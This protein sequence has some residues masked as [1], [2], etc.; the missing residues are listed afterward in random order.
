M[1]TQVIELI[2]RNRL[3]DELFMAGLEVAIPERDCGV[4]VIAYDLGSR[5][6]PFVARP[7]Q[8]K[9]ATGENFSIDQR[10]REMRGLILAFVWHVNDQRKP[11]T[12]ALTWREAL[13]IG[14]A[15]GWTETP[16]W[17]KHG[18]YTTQR[19]SQ[20]LLQLLDE[21]QMTP[22]LWRRKVRESR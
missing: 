5:S 13:A 6:I 2:G 15:M 14:R 3:I 11:V 12:Y 4:D 1:D 9:A 21:H 18:K 20:E 19:P 16:S 17:T 22:K 7:I 8:M 10:Y